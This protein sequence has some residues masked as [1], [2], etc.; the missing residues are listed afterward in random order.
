[1]LEAKGLKRSKLK[2]TH[3]IQKTRKEESSRQRSYIR[4]IRKTNSLSEL[5][6]L[7]KWVKK[8]KRTKH[9]LLNKIFRPKNPFAFTYAHFEE[10][11]ESFD[12]NSGELSYV[13]I[14]RIELAFGPH[15]EQT[16]RF[17]RERGITEY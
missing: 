1:M 13:L 14:R 12:K 4:F 9:M 15:I 6:S 8:D 10:L 11:C 16:K 2:K 7:Y 3:G 17:I 5:C